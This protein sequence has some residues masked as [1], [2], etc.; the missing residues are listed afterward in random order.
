MKI[1][2]IESFIVRAP[3]DSNKVYWGAG[4]WMSDPKQH[5][6]LPEGHPGDITTE[7]PPIWRLRPIYT[8]DL[9]CV[10]VR[11]ETDTGLVGWGEAH[12]PVAPEAAKAAIDAL[13]AG[14]VLGRDPLDI[15]PIW[16][17]MYSSM[18]MRGHS[19]GFL[20]EAIS[21]VD[22]ALWDLAGRA[23]GVPIST[24]LGG[25]VRERIPVY[26]SSLP[27]VHARAG[28][29][30]YQGL[31]DLARSLVDQGYRAFKV[32][33]GIDIEQ[34]RHSLRVLRKAVGPDVRICVDVNGAYDLAQ[35]RLAGR[36]MEEEGAYWL[37]EPLMPENWRGYADLAASLQIRVVAGECLFNRWQFNDYFVAGAVDAIN[38]DVGRAGGISECKRISDL[39]DTY[40]IPFSPHISIGSA[41][42]MAASLQWAAAGS[43]LNMC[44]WPMDVSAIGNGILKRPF[45]FQGGAI[46]L[47]ETPGLGIDID[48]D[49]LRRW[50]VRATS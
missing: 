41:I 43:N 29:A 47:D 19:T 21:G 12:T 3:I 30:G 34:D 48:E 39:A 16:E 20:L 32:K 49:K 8:R 23:L 44:E 13:L 45:Q 2:H 46:L 28:E 7:Y 50:Q 11:I 1:N 27:R 17:N 4:Y 15:Q 35:A 9:A 25:R 36:M 10:V 38:P 22:I 42:Y 31:A 40:G 5:P 6:G 26:A 33:L 37:E 14:I 24:L 18:R